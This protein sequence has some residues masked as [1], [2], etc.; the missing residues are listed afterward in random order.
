MRVAYGSLGLVGVLTPQANTTVEPEFGVLFP[1]GVAFINARMTSDSP[2]MNA[3]LVDYFDRL[4]V[5]AG[6]FANAPVDALAI[7]CT[8]ASYLVGAARERD[9]VDRLARRLGVPVITSGQAVGAAFAALGARRVALVS[10]YPRALT[11]ASV[12]YW[13]SYGVEIARIVE[14]GAVAEAFHPI[15]AMAAQDAH[16]ALAG[17][18]GEAGL[19]AVVMLGTGM[20]TL[21]PILRS[22]MVAGAP[23]L[24]CML[25]TAW[26]TVCAVGGQAP[27][28]PS[29][30]AWIRD[31]EWGPRLGD[32]L[33]FSAR[34]S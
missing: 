8:G 11:E 12:V 9:L 5:W 29:L 26:R 3:R 16:A 27:D 34:R 20:P 22:P 2:D 17:L 21:E 10:P 19:D 7:A 33:G 18:E 31:P 1:P 25:A 6:Q 4:D 30:L 28:G 32:R 13:Q 14:V 23:V 15:Y 24:S